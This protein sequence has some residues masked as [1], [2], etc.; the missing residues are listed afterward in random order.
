MRTIICLLFLLLPFSW[1]WAQPHPLD[2]LSA[3][4]LQR[5][6]EVLRERDELTETALFPI[7]TLAEPSKEEVHSF[8]G[9][10][11]PPRRAFAVILDREQ[12][13]VYETV[14]DLVAGKVQ[15]WKEVKGVQPG[16]LVE[17]FESPREWVKADP[18]WQA[19]IRKRGIED[20]ENVQV[21]TWAAGLLSEDLHQTGLRYLRCLS[22]YRPKGHTNPYYRPIEGIVALVDVVNKRV[23]RIEDNGDMA[24]VQKEG[25]SLEE[26]DNQPLR[27][28]LKPIFCSQP[29]GQGI[30][31][32]GYR[33][34]WQNWDFRYSMH[35]REGLVL[36]DVNYHDGDEVRSILYRGSLSEM[37]VP[38]GDVAPTWSFRNAFDLGEYG[39]GRLAN[40]LRAGYEVPDY[41]R[42]IDATFADDHGKPYVQKDAVA[43][44]ERE[45]G[46][47][48]KHYDFDT[49]HDETR[50]ARW[51]YLTYVATIGN[52]D[53][54]LSWIFGQDG[55]IKV[56]AQLTGIVLP[57]GVPITRSE[58]LDAQGH[59]RYGRL[60][61]PNVVAP[62]HQ[63][64]FNFRLDFD[65]DGVE[66]ILL[67]S[68][69]EAPPMGPDNP[70][71]N[72][73]MRRITQLRTEQEAQRDI[74]INTARTWLVANPRQK[75]ALGQNTAYMI[76]PGELAVPYLR[77][78]APVRKRAGFIDHQLW[79]TAF[80]P[81]E[82][83]A[84]GYYPNQNRESSGLPG[85]CRDNQSLDG[86]DLVLWYTFGV[87]HNVRP[88]EWPVMPSHKTG[89]GIYPNGFFSRNPAMD[90]PNP[91]P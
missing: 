79:G 7:V 35:P 67:E 33:V 59:E 70:M 61:G 69:N 90:V 20:L 45:L 52:Y 74:D 18:R 85:W 60:V 23:V 29:E 58:S 31:V 73:F 48:W 17:E 88:E 71:G 72:A 68:N 30:E 54:A 56:Q 1:C 42:L 44:Y 37:V 28:Q 62:N 65:V 6:V 13:H 91:R 66:N 80:K 22:Y 77:A 41:A 40:T 83:N 53:Y 50:R 47:L 32:E 81:E 63:H 49:G 12:N 46:I 27:D 38:Y 82:L 51:L 55:S 11:P 86:K 34:R 24:G 8:N 87:T 76:A 5:T 21:D 36:H 78:E 25:G 43:V 57:K 39:V 89:F 2:P 15:S 19:A 4:E 14:V 64:F 84:A 26:K 3:E 10:E 75:N 16:V 9:D